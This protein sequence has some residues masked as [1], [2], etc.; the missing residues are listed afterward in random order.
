MFDKEMC[1]QLLTRI[2]LLTI[3][4]VLNFAISLSRTR[5]R[6]EEEGERRA[7]YFSERARRALHLTGRQQPG[8]PAQIRRGTGDEASARAR[9]WLRFPVFL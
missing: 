8:Q 1:V 4:Y 7:E 9:R 6:R 5:V 2:R 3:E